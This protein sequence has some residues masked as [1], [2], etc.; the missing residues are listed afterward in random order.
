L[1]F[2]LE[3]K[4]ISKADY[5]FYSD[6]WRKSVLTGKQE[7]WRIDINK[8]MLSNISLDKKYPSKLDNTNIL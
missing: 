1:N 6:T 8:R 4:Y 7:K 2:A 5:N 3:R